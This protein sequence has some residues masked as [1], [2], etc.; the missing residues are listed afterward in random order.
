MGVSD[1]AVMKQMAK[2]KFE[3]LPLDTKQN[4]LKNG[5]LLKYGQ[6]DHLMSLLKDTSGTVLAESSPFDLT[7]GTGKR[8]TGVFYMMRP[9]KRT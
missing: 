7:W 8:I 1:P 9:I 5:M 6:N 4:T 2:G 3:R